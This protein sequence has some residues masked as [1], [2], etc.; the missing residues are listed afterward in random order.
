MTRLL[1]LLLSA[2]LALLPLAAQA[3]VTAAF[4]SFNGSYFGGRY[5]HAFVVLDG[6]LA[7]GSRVHENFGYS[8]DAGAIAA[9]A[10]TVRGTIQVEKETYI[11]KTNRHFAVPISDDQYRALI[12]EREAWRDAPGQKR[13]SLDHRNCI[14]F[15]ARLAELV[16]I[17]APVPQ[18]MV[19]RPKLWL[20][21]VTRL[22]PQLG[23]SEIK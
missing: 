1:A 8:T 23:A 10:G 6:T 21:Y 2:L 7:D 13:Y 22:N 15:V 5:P 18:N 9:L 17:N 20:N 3:Q 11:R 16:G 19:R 4:H 12:A 14:H